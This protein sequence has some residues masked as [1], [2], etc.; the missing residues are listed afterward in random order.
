MILESVCLCGDIVRVLGR[1]P[2]RQSRKVAKLWDG[3]VSRY[4]CSL[5]R[6][7][8]SCPKVSIS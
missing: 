6:N 7:S 4:P 1:G 8:L 3:V 5:T 2:K